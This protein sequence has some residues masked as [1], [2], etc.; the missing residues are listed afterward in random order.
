MEIFENLKLKKKHKYIEPNN[1]NFKK[2]SV[3]LIE[4]LMEV[5]MDFEEEQKPWDQEYFI[6]NGNGYGNGMKFVQAMA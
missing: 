2:I 5:F 6:Q 4:V 1:A 3:Q